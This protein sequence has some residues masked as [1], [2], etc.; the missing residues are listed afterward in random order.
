MSFKGI[1]VK[2]NPRKNVYSSGR[3][4][5]YTTLKELTFFQDAITP[6]F[7]ALLAD[8]PSSIN[9]HDTI[10]CDICTRLNE[11]VSKESHLACLYIVILIFFSFLEFI[12]DIIAFVLKFYTLFSY[13]LVA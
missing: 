5:T 10:I 3:I 13:S 1:L 7:C 11:E 12:L 9:E 6:C 4:I 2:K 8:L